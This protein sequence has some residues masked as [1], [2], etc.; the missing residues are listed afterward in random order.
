[1]MPIIVAVVLIYAAFHLGW[2][3]ATIVIERRI[4]RIAK[5]QMNQVYKDYGG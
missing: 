5:E 3:W 4:Q 1:M 2:T